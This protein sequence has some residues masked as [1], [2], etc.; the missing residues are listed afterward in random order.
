MSN[1]IRYTWVVGGDGVGHLFQQDGLTGLGLSH[2]QATLAFADG[3]EE[4]HDAGR[5]GAAFMP[6]DV[7][8]LVGE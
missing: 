4:V 5:D 6:R 3:G 8:L 2:N 7:E 1:I